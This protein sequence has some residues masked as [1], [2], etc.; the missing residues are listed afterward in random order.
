MWEPEQGPMIISG[1]DLISYLEDLGTVE[2]I[3]VLYC[4]QVNCS[5]TIS[6]PQALKS[7]L[8]A[9]ETNQPCVRGGK[10][11]M[12]WKSPSLCHPPAKEKHKVLSTF[13]SRI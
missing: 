4:H 12:T 8:P 3:K 11:M 6:S 9:G 13:L 10:A 2:Y 5:T 1:W 7:V